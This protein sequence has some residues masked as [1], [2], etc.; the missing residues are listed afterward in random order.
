MCGQSQFY[1]RIHSWDKS[2]F[3]QEAYTP[4]ETLQNTLFLIVPAFPHVIS[5]HL[6]A[7]PLLLELSAQQPILQTLAV[8]FKVTHTFC[9][10]PECQSQLKGKGMLFAT[11]VCYLYSTEKSMWKYIFQIYSHNQLCFILIRHL[12]F[13]VWRMI[14]DCT[15][16]FGAQKYIETR[17]AMYISG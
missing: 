17:I 2:V 3:C 5:G 9:E 14:A 6:L 11:L 4:M 7:Q 10:Y 12:G 8:S 15:S 13:L 1:D 16:V